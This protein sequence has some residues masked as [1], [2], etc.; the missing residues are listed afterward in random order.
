V[1]QRGGTH[2]QQAQNKRDGQ[3]GGKRTPRGIQHEPGSTD[4]VKTSC[5]C[6]YA[7]VFLRFVARLILRA[8]RAISAGVRIFSSTIP[9]R[10][11][12]TDPDQRPVLAGPD[13]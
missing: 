2:V 4:N 13:S 9:V 7:S 5:A 6:S 3:R 8:R 11:C 1:K 10:N 12:S